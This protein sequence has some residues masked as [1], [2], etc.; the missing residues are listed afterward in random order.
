[1]CSR[2]INFQGH[3]LQ[4]RSWFLK[5]KYPEK[6]IDEGMEKSEFF[7]ANLQAKKCEK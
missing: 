5:K 4:L 7:P 3:F 1:M 2:K 6:L